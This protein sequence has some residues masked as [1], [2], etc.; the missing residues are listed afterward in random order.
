[1]DGF[2]A[3]ADP[4]RRTIVEMLAEGELDA[5]SIA[6][7]FDVS[8][9]AV[10]RHLRVLRDAGIVMARTD[11]QRRV[12]ALRPRGLAD[13]ETWVDRHR[14]FWSDRLAVLERIIEEE[15]T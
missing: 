14:E 6:D 2:T 4:T 15:K 10:S 9:P 8:R 3:L 13:V 1:M 7:R 5:G 11:A 12:Y